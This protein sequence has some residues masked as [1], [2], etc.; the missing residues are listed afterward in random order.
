[1]LYLISGV[2]RGG[3][4]P[5]NPDFFCIVKNGVT[6]TGCLI[7]RVTKYS[8]F[9]D[10]YLRYFPSNSYPFANILSSFK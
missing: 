2:A 10:A 4:G 5:P 1:M 3:P 9:Q 6:V 7:Y 8:G